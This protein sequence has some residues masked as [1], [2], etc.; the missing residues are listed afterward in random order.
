MQLICLEIVVILYWVGFEG[1]GSQFKN[2]LILNM[3]NNGK[4]C[5]HK[6]HISVAEQGS[7][8]IHFISLVEI[9]LSTFLGWFR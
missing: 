1:V 4:F 3:K 6:S 8:L 7:T 9:F 5:K 2:E